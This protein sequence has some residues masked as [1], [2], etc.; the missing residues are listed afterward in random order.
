MTKQIKLIKFMIV[1][2]IFI[3]II[4]FVTAIVQTFILKNKQAEL[5]NA[6]TY[7]NER[8][9]ELEKQQDIL[10][11]VESDEY[12]QEYKKHNDPNKGNEEE[13]SINIP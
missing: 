2:L 10:D 3:P 9:D 1:V 8:N 11:Y 4:L 12:K 5:N 7:L 6:N 13:F